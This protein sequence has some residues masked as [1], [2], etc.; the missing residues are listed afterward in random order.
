M[1]IAGEAL[2]NNQYKYIICALCVIRNLESTPMLHTH[3]ISTFTRRHVGYAKYRPLGEKARI[4][5]P[6]SHRTADVLQRRC[7]HP[8]KGNLF[9]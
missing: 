2:D 9:W 5:F 8:P 4:Q 6:G 3:I 7:S 1:V